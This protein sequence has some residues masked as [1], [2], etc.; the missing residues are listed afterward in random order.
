MAPA[1][2]LRPERLGRLWMSLVQ[3]VMNTAQHSWQALGWEIGRLPGGDVLAQGGIEG[4]FR[5]DAELSTCPGEPLIFG[6]EVAGSVLLCQ[7]QQHRVRE[8]GPY[9][10]ASG[11]VDVMAAP[12]R[13]SRT[14]GPAANGRSLVVTSLA[15]KL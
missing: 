6:G 2:G 9:L 1:A 5:R 12:S 14:T 8:V 3:P 13:S 11:R 4:R 7:M 15:S 10:S